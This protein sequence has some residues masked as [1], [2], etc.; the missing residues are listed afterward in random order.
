MRRGQLFTKTTSDI[1][2]QPWP[3]GK[4]AVGACII[5]ARQITRSLSRFIYSQK[6]NAESH[7]IHS[8]DFEG[9][10]ELHR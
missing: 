8:P 4:S 9:D 7:M 2:I 10:P 6:Q 1:G 3:E 5:F